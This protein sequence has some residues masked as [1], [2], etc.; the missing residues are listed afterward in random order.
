MYRSLVQKFRDGDLIPSS[1]MIKLPYIGDYLY[2]RL[3]RKFT[4]RSQHIT[5][6]QFSR[7][8][9][10]IPT[11]QLK[12]ELQRV[13]QNERA[14]QCV[15]K[16]GHRYHVRDT[17]EKGLQTTIAFL[18]VIKNNADGHNLGANMTANPQRI[19]Y[20]R[21][22]SEAAKYSPC[23]SRSICRAPNVWRSGL[24]QYND[25]SGF[26]GIG[27]Y[28]GQSIRTN[29]SQQVQR[30]NN[31]ERSRRDARRDRDTAADIRNGHGG[32]KYSIVNE[33]T[34]QRKPSK[35]VRLPL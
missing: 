25:S 29:L 21:F 7:A 18:R 24:C 14:N 12:D 22:R 8:I 6:R 11:A 31:L 13:M 26:E 35:I 33:R 20:P 28:P 15:G 17:N 2:E 30:A 3:R 9:R 4:P 19:A 5:L 16:R 10:D 27:R 34:R 1:K 23:K 32:M